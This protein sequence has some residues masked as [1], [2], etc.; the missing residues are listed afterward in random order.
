MTSHMEAPKISKDPAA[1]NTDLYAFISPDNTKT[2]TIIANYIPLEEPAGGPNFHSFDD[3]VLYEINI[4]NDGD[5]VEEVVYQFRFKTDPLPTS[6][7]LYNSGPIHFENGKYT[8]LNLVQ[9]YSVTRIAGGQS[10]VLGSGLLTAPA[11][12]GPESTPTYETEL[13]SPATI[14]L[15]TGETVFAGPRAEGFYV[16]LG[17]IFDLLV[18]RPFGGAYNPPFPHVTPP[19][20]PHATSGGGVNDTSG[21]N[22]H[23]IAI[24]VPIEELT[25]NGSRPTD[26]FDPAAVIGIYAS[27][28]RQKATVLGT[29]PGG[30][31]S[32]AGPFTQISRLGVPLINEVLIPMGL[33]DFWN[34]SDPKDDSQFAQFYSNPEPAGLVHAL[35]P[36]VN[37]PTTP[38]GDIVAALL[39]GFSLKPLGLPFT[40]AT[41]V[42]ADLLRLNLA[43][44]PAT[45]PNRLGILARAA[46]NMTPAPDLAGFPNGRRVLDDVIDIEVQAL[47]GATPFTPDFN[48]PPNSLLGDGVD[49]PDKPFL[50]MFPYLATP[51][52]GYVHV[53]THD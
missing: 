38:R 19:I 12:I 46:D 45:S 17:S 31:G 32:V 33:K 36:A 28:S 11:N 26:P 20:P 44:P 47:A 21:Y 16:D 10:T 13:V 49:A 43:V 18:L 29:G 50:S 3:N 42:Q 6:T 14:T 52:Q 34:S 39:T 41:T 51:Q 5:G 37:V 53:H 15:P 24:Q 4:D 8:N 48:K 1:D 27:A 30:A 35:Y 40:N 2:V 7:F 23:S 22:V 9:K 25:N